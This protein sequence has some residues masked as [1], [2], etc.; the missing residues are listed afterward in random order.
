MPLL[1]HKTGVQ[2]KAGI[3]H[4]PNLGTVLMV[5]RTLMEADGPISKSELKRRLSRKVMHPTLNLILEYLEDSGKVFVGEKGV[6]WIFNDNPNLRRIV[7][8]ATIVK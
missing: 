4:M 3:L 5:E 8:R 7:E 1:T 6:E 2:A